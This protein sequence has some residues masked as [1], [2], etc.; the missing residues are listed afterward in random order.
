MKKVR[1]EFSLPNGA[2]RELLLSFTE[3]NS[4]TDGFDYGY[5]GSN[6]DKDLPIDMSW[7]IN[8][9]KFVIQGVGKFNESKKYPLGLFLDRKAKVNISLKSLDNFETEQDIYIYDALLGTTSS[10]ND[11]NYELDLETGI[12]L[13]RFYLVFKNDETNQLSN[14]P[15]SDNIILEYY[16]RSNEI[17][18]SVPKN[19][20]IKQVGLLNILGQRVKAWNATNAPMSQ[21]L[22]L[23]VG[24]LSAGNY[25]IQLETDSNEL[26]NKKIIVSD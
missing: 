4:A 26:V 13:N 24:N 1:L 9:E 11:L 23:K 21:E 19:I 16:N 25:I 17:S 2:S 15:N 18:I 3:D 5:D 12:Y 7:M 10:I 20:N 8:D 6:N 22:R 14:I